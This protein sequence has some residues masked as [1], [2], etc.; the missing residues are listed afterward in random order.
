[1]DLPEYAPGILQALMGGGAWPHGADPRES[2]ARDG[3]GQSAT[4]SLGVGRDSRCGGTRSVVCPV[5]L[6]LGDQ[7]APMA[8]KGAQ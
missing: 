1:M 3:G 7:R 6:A 2:A 5:G 8:T 4:H